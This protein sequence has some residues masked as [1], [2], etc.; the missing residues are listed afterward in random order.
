[1]CNQNNIYHR[2]AVILVGRR[3]RRHHHDDED[4]VSVMTL[5]GAMASFA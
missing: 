4:T 5:I 2:V 3:R 1:M